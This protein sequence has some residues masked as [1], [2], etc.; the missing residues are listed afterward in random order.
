M[1]ININ[2]ELEPVILVTLNAKH[3]AEGKRFI[4]IACV[5][6]NK[7]RICHLENINFPSVFV[8]KKWGLLHILKV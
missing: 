7:R 1:K 8:L 5:Y 4:I 6:E 3:L 2:L